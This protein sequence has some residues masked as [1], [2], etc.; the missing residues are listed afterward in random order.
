MPLQYVPPEQLSDADIAAL[1]EA[2]LAGPGFNSI[3]A[4]DL[5]HK[6]WKGEFKLYKAEGK[7]C[8]LV[9]VNQG[10]DGSCRLNI[11]RASGSFLKL[12]LS[13]PEM[14]ASLQHIAR[15]FGCNAI[16][17]VVYSEKLAKAL[18]RSGAKREAT[19]MVLESR[20]G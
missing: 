12:V 17:A 10:G 11:V 5:I 8:F 18:T 9:E 16:E 19:V 7:G 14:K 2:D 3:P 20:H 4:C 15:D 6:V 1:V 13:T